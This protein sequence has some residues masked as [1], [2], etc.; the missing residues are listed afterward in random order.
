[1]ISV[2]KLHETVFA[3]AYFY[4]TKT[5]IS[6]LPNLWKTVLFVTP[7]P[8]ARMR[9][10]ICK[11][12]WTPHAA[13]GPVWPTLWW[14]C[15]DAI[16]R[17]LILIL[18]KNLLPQVHEAMRYWDTCVPPS[19]MFSRCR[20]ETI[21]YLVQNLL[22]CRAVDDIKTNACVYS[23]STFEKW[24]RKEKPFFV[25][26]RSQDSG[27]HLKRYFGWEIRGRVRSAYWPG[28]DNTL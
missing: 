25:R 22:C 24:K 15:F 2:E 19:L 3:R 5:R 7:L 8:L 12:H 6:S 11:S 26:L 9:S 14:S 1:M 16:F 21:W 20:Y 18:L 23:I 27:V 13:Y 10:R 17:L 28:V 4:I